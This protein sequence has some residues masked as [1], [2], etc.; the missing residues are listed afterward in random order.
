V[1]RDGCVRRST[2]STCPG[3]LD[4]LL[5]RGM[6]SL[7]AGG[8][9]PNRHQGRQGRWSGHHGNGKRLIR[10]VTSVTWVTGSSRSFV[11]LRSPTA[12]VENQGSQI[13]QITTSKAFNASGAVPLGLVSRPR[14]QVQTNGDGVRVGGACSASMTTSPFRKGS[15]T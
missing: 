12:D 2:S 5:G 10:M 7:S 14:V 3:V 9:W 15:G 1:R 11:G 6:P 13:T 4:E 8:K